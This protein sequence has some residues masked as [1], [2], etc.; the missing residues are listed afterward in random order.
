MSLD[1]HTAQAQLTPEERRELLR[2][3]ADRMLL[4]VTAMD[5]PE[6]MPGVEK[7]VRT[8]AVIE[9]VY[10]RCDRAE[11]QK[12]EPRKLQAERAHHESE[13]IKARVSLA[14]TLKWGEERRQSLGQWWDD[15][16][17]LV[18]TPVQEA[19]PATSHPQKPAATEH[20]VAMDGLTEVPSWQKVTYVDYTEAFE[21]ARAEL[22]L[23]RREA[24]SAQVP[25]QNSG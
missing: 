23:Q 15:A 25:P 6:D 7:A 16:K 14:N 17:N 2:A 1:D 18:Q 11:R 8:A 13:A 12:P 9:R 10:S 4:K 21:A 24:K 20:P 19:A 3:F 22:V 5:D